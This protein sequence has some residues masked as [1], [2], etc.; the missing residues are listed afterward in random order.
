M[1]VLILGFKKKKFF[2]MQLMK[3]QPGVC[4]NVKQERNH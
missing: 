4:K 3:V 1:F 2:V